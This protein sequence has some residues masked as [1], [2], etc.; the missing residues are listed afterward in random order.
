M[1]A[2]LEREITA[3]QRWRI[4]TELMDELNGCMADLCAPS[5]NFEHGWRQRVGGEQCAG[6][7]GTSW[8]AVIVLIRLIRTPHATRGLTAFS[9]YFQANVGSGFAGQRA[10]STAV[11]L[12]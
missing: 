1:D 6:K 4:L 12:I 8:L 5:R 11:A 2:L 7:S 3:A 9:M 10:S